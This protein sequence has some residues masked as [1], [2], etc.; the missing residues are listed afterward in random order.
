[1]HTN[2]YAAVLNVKLLHLIY[3]FNS[4]LFVLNLNFQIESVHKLDMN[5]YVDFQQSM[6]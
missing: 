3:G 5:L 1:M 4:S 2:L 6:N